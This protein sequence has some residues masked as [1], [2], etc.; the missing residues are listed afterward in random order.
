MPEHLGST[1]SVP[2]IKNQQTTTTDTTVEEIRFF[3]RRL[4]NRWPDLCI[5]CKSVIKETLN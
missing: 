5:D 2:N 1:R 4:K 3:V